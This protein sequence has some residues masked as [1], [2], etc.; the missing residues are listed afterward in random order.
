VPPKLA[1]FDLD[2]TLIDRADLFRRWALDFLRRQGKDVGEVV[3]LVEQDAD[4]LMP[5]DAFFDAVRNRYEI[6]ATTADLVATYS[7]EYPSF[8]ADPRPDLLAALTTLRDKGWRLGIVTNGPPMQEQVVDRAGLRSAVDAVCVS[9]T[10]G[11]R[12]PDPA[13]FRLAA[14][15]CERALAGGWMIGD[16]A[17]HDIRGATAAG[18]KSIWIA[19]GRD[20]VEAGYEPTLIAETDTDAIAMLV[21]YEPDLG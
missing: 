3:W 6:D 4:G 18:M 7:A 19:R 20:W 2:N 12:K 14:D 13:I 16:S 10:V 9:A 15:R 21:A 17:T 5:R 8:T 11:L 1:L